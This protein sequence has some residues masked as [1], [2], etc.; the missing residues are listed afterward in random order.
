MIFDVGQRGRSGAAVFGVVPRQIRCMLAGFDGQP[1][2]TSPAR[3]KLLR[4]MMSG[5]QKII[6][7]ETKETDDTQQEAR[8]KS[9]SI[10]NPAG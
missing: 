4:H 9:V 5:G 3:H 1:G 6:H 8:A 2:Q 10:H 7:R